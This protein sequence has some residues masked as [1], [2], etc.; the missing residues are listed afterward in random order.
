MTQSGRLSQA[1]QYGPTASG[2]LFGA[3]WWF[4]LDAIGSAPSKVPFVQVRDLDARQPW[5]CCLHLGTSDTSGWAQWG[6]L[7]GRGDIPLDSQLGPD[8]L[9]RAFGKDA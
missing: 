5:L 9:K 7:T 1:Q 6:E 8:A 4:W 3:G 2:A